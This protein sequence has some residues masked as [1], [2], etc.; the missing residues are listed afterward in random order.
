[1][2][3]C[4]ECSTQILKQWRGWPLR[5][6]VPL[7]PRV[8]D[9]RCE[10]CES[11]SEVISNTA[12]QW[13]NYHGPSSTGLPDYWLLV[14]D[15]E[16]I[17]GLPYH[18]ESVCMH[19]GSRAV[20]SEHGDSRSSTFEY[21]VGC[22]P[23]HDVE[24]KRKHAELDEKREVK[25]QLESARRHERQDYCRS[26]AKLPFANRLIA[27]AA[28]KSI[29]AYVNGREWSE[30]K[31]DWSAC[32]SEE[33]DA[34]SADDIENLLELCEN[35]SVLCS[36]GVRQRL[37]DQRHQ[38]RQVAIGE[39]RLK[40]GSMSHEDQLTELV[41]AA[42]IPISH[43][44]VELAVVVTDDWLRTIPEEQKTRFLKQLSA[45]KLRVWTRARKRLSSAALPNSALDE[46]RD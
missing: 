17:W 2:N 14:T 18:S 6:P 30:W 31:G 10:A 38:L 32:S 21:R 4:K 15:Q 34:F 25:R 33:I 8:M 19:C 45:C 42:T 20:L 1:M 41:V 9:G 5:E 26:L 37:Y 44:P 16:T 3:Y 35:N 46:A 27:I 40:Y 29:D 7:L 12:I 23:C 22:P 43:F 39:I 36:L 13:L 11:Q 28:D 24:S